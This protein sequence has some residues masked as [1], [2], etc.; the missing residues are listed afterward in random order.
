MSL[1]R[2]FVAGLPHLGP[3]KS[4]CKACQNRRYR[5]WGGDPLRER[6]RSRMQLRRRS[7]LT[8]T[9]PNSALSRTS[10]RPGTRDGGCGAFRRAVTAPV[11]EVPPLQCRHR[12]F[13]ASA[14]PSVPCAQRFADAGPV[15]ARSGPASGHGIARGCRVGHSGNPGY[16]F[17][18]WS[19]AAITPGMERDPF[20]SRPLLGSSALL[21]LDHCQQVLRPGARDVAVGIGPSAVLRRHLDDHNGIG[22]QALETAP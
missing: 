15:P 2:Y 22:L 6:N 13:L 20:P 9:C 8:G 3:R 21:D 4:V 1:G 16:R 19:M 12:T 14:S 17:Q 5:C 10:A 7:D 11:T 18:D